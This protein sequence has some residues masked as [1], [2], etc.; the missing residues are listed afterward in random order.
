MEYWHLLGLILK[1]LKNIPKTEEWFLNLDIQN[2]MLKNCWKL[3]F[4]NLKINLYYYN[5][6]NKLVGLNKN[7]I[8]K[9]VETDILPRMNS[10]GS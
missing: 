1:T 9:I 8:R 4:G 3:N 10:W 6:K 2:P 7:D 5:M